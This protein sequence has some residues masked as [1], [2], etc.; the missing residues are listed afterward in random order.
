MNYRPVSRFNVNLSGYYFSKQTQ[1]DGSYDSDDTASAQFANGQ[2]KSKFILNAKVSYE[3]VKNLTVFASGRNILN[4]DS[5]EFYA[6]DRTAGLY[7]AG[8]SLNMT[9]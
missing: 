6:G 7:S 2:I 8:L 1:Y 4:S 9:K 5:R 3:V